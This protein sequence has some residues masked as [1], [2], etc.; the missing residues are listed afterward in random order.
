[1]KLLM[2]IELQCCL[3]AVQLGN[4][5]DVPNRRPGAETGA[6]SELQKRILN[7]KSALI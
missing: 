1:M 7:Y 2:A 3:L 4:R 6:H 5:D